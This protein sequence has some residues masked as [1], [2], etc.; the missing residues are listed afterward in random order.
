MLNLRDSGSLEKEA[1]VVCFLYRPEYYGITEDE[2]G[3]PTYGIGEVIIAKH[4]NGSLD[5]VGL[6][7]IGKYTKFTDRDILDIP[8]FGSLPSIGG[9]PAE[10]D[11][12]G[13]IRP[14]TSMN[15][16]PPSSNDD[17]PPF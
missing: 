13:I 1:D 5:T 16:K 7:F 10:F 11:M 8:G 14:G 12:P 4:R 6:K 2:V 3:N 9:I 17:L 15:T